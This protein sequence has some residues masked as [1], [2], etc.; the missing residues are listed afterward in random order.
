MLAI[1]FSSPSKI[2]EPMPAASPKTPAST[3]PPIESPSFL[4]FSISFSISLIIS[5]FKTAIGLFLMFLNSVTLKFK[6]LNS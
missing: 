6:E 5:S 3:I 2:G 4:A 1:K